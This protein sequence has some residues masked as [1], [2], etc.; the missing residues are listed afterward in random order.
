[1]VI[2]PQVLV[3]N[4]LFDDRGTALLSTVQL[5]PALTDFAIHAD[6]EAVLLDSG[7]D[8]NDLPRCQELAELHSRSLTRLRLS[9]LDGPAD[10]NVLRLN[11][12]PQLRSFALE[13]DQQYPPINLRIDAASFE[14]TPQ[15]QS[16][17]L[18]DVKKLVLQDGSLRQL[19]AL[20]ALRVTG[21]DL[22]SV[23]ADLASAG[24]MLR[25]L[26]MSMNFELQLSGS[27]VTTIPQCSRLERLGMSRQGE[28]DAE[29]V[30]HL[31]NLLP[32]FWKQHG[33]DLDIFDD[34]DSF[35]KCSG[36][37]F[38]LVASCM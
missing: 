13:G 34:E 38:R 12:L 2:A 21:C 28:L 6:P 19:T 37:D 30:R 5:L 16:L 22:R 20:T 9:M 32:A 3:R 29:T 35:E 7:S 10:G 18:L 11:G 26:D 23:P 25:V 36:T 24:R 14:G 27:E 31:L 4:V 15:L 17:Q 8:D 1:M 33:R